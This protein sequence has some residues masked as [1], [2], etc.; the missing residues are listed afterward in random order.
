MNLDN[1][2]DPAETTRILSESNYALDLSESTAFL[3]KL[4]EGI[5]PRIV[6]YRK[7]GA[8]PRVARLAKL[9]KDI[10]VEK[11]TAFCPGH[12]GLLEEASRAVN[13]IRGWAGQAQ[14]AEEAANRI[15]RLRGEDC[16][17]I[18]GWREN[19]IWSPVVQRL[20][21]HLLDVAATQE[22][23]EKQ[24]ADAEETVGRA[25]RLYAGA[26]ARYAGG[27]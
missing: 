21:L 27:H 4:A 8:D 3:N 5:E 2:P 10:D 13:S 19:N 1:L 16:G 26:A 6:T 9:V 25:V 7:M 22:E 11:F 17:R 24:L 12:H 15:S 23:L 20:S 14:R 18:P